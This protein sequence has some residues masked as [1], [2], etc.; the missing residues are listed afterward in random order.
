MSTLSSMRP[1]WVLVVVVVF[2]PKDAP[3][4]A[5]MHLSTSAKKHIPKTRIYR[6]VVLL[7]DAI[8]LEQEAVEY[9]L[10]RRRNLLRIA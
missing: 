9:I 7:A 2:V 4:V 3:L 10:F 5:P 6:A 1:S 8:V